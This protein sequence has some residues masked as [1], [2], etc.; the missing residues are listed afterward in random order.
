MSTELTKHWIRE[1][2]T[3]LNLLQAEPNPDWITQ[4]QIDATKSQ[5]QDLRDQIREWR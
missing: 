3:S 2:E 1:F 5:L 4:I